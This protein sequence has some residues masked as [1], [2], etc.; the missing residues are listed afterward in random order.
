MMRES[1]IYSNENFHV[2]FARR[3]CPGEKS[4]TNFAI[5][6]RSN[7][8]RVNFCDPSCRQKD[9]KSFF[10]KALEICL[11]Y[12]TTRRST[13]L[14]TFVPHSYPPTRGL[15]KK[16]TTSTGVGA[17]RFA[18]NSQ[19]PRANMSP[20]IPQCLFLISRCLSVLP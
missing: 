19:P 7:Q 14:W 10:A 4:H 8:R 16:R 3:A 1:L 20:T 2:A 17:P 6:H 11:F 12:V 18:R 13:M 15:Q 9:A 5:K